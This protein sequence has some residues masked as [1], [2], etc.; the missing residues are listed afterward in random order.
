MSFACPTEKWVT[1]HTIG[2]DANDACSWIDQGQIL[3]IGRSH[4]A[5]ASTFTHGHMPPLS[6]MVERVVRPKE[7]HSCIPIG[8]LPPLVLAPNRRKV[9]PEEEVEEPVSPFLVTSQK[10][11]KT[12]RSLSLK[13]GH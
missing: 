11:A 5:D 1:S 12:M 13:R 4:P 10:L 6:A 9:E 3:D 2:S 8:E 7:P